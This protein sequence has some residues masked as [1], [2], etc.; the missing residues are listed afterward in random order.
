MSGADRCAV[1]DAGHLVLARSAATFV[2]AVIQV[3]LWQRILVAILVNLTPVI[4]AALGCGVWIDFAPEG[5]TWR[6]ECEDDRALED[7]GGPAAAI[8]AADPAPATRDRPRVLVVE[9]EALIAMEVV[10]TLEDAGYQ[11]VGP[12]GTVARALD[13]VE[14]IGCDHA[15]LDVNLG[16]ETAEPVALRL[17]ALGVPFLSLSGYARAQQPPAFH[18]APALSKPLRPKELLEE[19]ARALAA[20]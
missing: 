4:L 16:R 1:E 3:A 6:I 11:V 20:G 15:V 5:L 13:L 10:A 12:A 8:A 7:A 17:R 18:G 2:I 19:L 14:R 9:D